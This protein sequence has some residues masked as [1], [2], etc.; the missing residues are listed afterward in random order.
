MKGYPEKRSYVS[1]PKKEIAKWSAVF[2]WYR[3][4]VEDVK[5]TLRHRDS[6]SGT[7]AGVAVPGRFRHAG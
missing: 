5:I 6:R 4:I 7:A 2:P 1:D 3:R